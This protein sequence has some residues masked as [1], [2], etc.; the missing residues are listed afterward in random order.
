M[1]R[2]SRRGI[3]RTMPT[4]RTPPPPSLGRS[5]HMQLSARIALRLARENQLYVVI[6]ADGLFLVQNDPSVVK[7][8]AR[9]VLTPNVVE[10]GRL[11]ESCVSLAR[12]VGLVGGALLVSKPETPPVFHQD[13]YAVELEPDPLFWEPH[14]RT[15]TRHF[16]IPSSPRPSRERSAVLRSSKRDGTTGSRTA[17]RRSSVA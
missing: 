12:P 7:G 9:A 10:F 17:T 11:V 8:Y 14:R 3:K 2:S 4:H 13:A 16:R 15:S 5:E 1:I 6:D